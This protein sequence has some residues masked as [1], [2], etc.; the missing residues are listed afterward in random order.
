VRDVL[1]WLGVG[2]LGGLGA[3]ARFV[4][5]GLPLGTFAVNIGGTLLLGLLVGLAVSG[6]ALLL[7]ATALLASYTTFSAWM[8]ETH[9]LAERGHRVAAAVNLIASLVLGVAA[10]ALGRWIAGG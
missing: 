9:G 6:D 7:A 8:A 4:V 1:V 5:G 2:V 10:A 3:I